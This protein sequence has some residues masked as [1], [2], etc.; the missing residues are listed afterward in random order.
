MKVGHH[1]SVSSLKGKRGSQQTSRDESPLLDQ[2]ENPALQLTSSPAPLSQCPAQ[3]IGVRARARVRA[4]ASEAQGKLPSRGRGK[5]RLRQQR[6]PRSR[7]ME[8]LCAPAV[9]CKEGN[10]EGF[11]WH[12]CPPPPDASTEAWRRLLS[13][14]GNVQLGCPPRLQRE[15]RGVRL[16]TELGALLCFSSIPASQEP[17]QAPQS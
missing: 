6:L 9:T 16:A 4:C 2:Q 8:R 1:V 11:A 17:F 13:R 10:G 15:K 14:A 7:K 3:L 12:Q 5:G